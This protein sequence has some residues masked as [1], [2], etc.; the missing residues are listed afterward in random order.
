MKHII[1]AI[2]MTF[3]AGCSVSY[4][5]DLKRLHS[6]TINNPDQVPIIF[7]PGITGSKLKNKSD[8]QEIWPQGYWQL[9]THDFAELATQINPK[10]LEAITDQQ[11][12][13]SITDRVAGRDFYNKLIA[14]LENVAGFRQAIPGTK[15]SHLKHYYVF[16]YDWRQDNAITAKKLHNFIEQIRKDYNKP[17]LKVDIIAHSMGGLI[18]RYY[19]RY[20]PQ[21]VL[22]SNELPVNL[23]GA[24]NLRRVVLLGTPNFGSISSINTMIDGLPLVFNSIEPQTL[25]TMPSMYQLF[26]H[27]LND[28]LINHDGKVLQRDQFDI[29]LWQKFEWSIFNPDIKKEII[30]QNGAEYYQTLI[31]FFEKHL[32]RA[33]RFVWSLSVPYEKTESKIIAFGGDCHLTPAR[34]V[35]EEIDGESVLRMTPSSIKNKTADVDYN[36][37]MLEPGDG[38]VT[39]ASLLARHSLDPSVPRHKYSFFPVDYTFFLCEQHHQLTS[40]INFQDNLLHVLLSRDL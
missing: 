25:A 1:I 26:P 23:S 27:A 30:N 17:H 20:G 12:A 32:E 28:W 18:T 5:P 10:T 39:K 33:R 7:I 29:N 37:I 38:T 13:Y 34:V 11:E 31:R 36:E 35:I 21:D 22:D 40:N 16:P 6:T 14:V 19:L 4:K 24:K 8:H 2:L 9:M 15:A 3:I